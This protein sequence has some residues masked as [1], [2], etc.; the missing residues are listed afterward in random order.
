MQDHPQLRSDRGYHLTPIKDD[1][2]LYTCTSVGQPRPP[3]ELD[4]L[5][6]E[7]ESAC[8]LLSHMKSKQEQ[9]VF[10]MLQ[11]APCLPSPRHAAQFQEQRQQLPRLSPASAARFNSCGGRRPAMLMEN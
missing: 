11:A 6:G 8:R 10:D 4:G 7:L 9:D 5:V 1:G 2:Q 3:S